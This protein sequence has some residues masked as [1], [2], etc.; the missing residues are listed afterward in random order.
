MPS[1]FGV[2]ASPAEVESKSTVAAL[3]AAVGALT[4]KA[5][6]T[7]CPPTASSSS[8]SLQSAVAEA[9]GGVAPTESDGAR[10]D[11]GS[12]RRRNLPASWPDMLK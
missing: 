10:E 2:T 1:P 9:A 8:R 5:D 3:Q 12:P 4:A 7:L 6:R 11:P